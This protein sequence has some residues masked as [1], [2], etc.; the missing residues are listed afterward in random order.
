MVRSEIGGQKAKSQIQIYFR[1][2]NFLTY[3]ILKSLKFWWIWKKSF[4]LFGEPRNQQKRFGQPGSTVNNSIKMV[5]FLSI[6]VNNV[7]YHVHFNANNVT[8]Q[9]NVNNVA[10]IAFMDCIWPL[11]AHFNPQCYGEGV[12]A[13]NLRFVLQGSY[14]VARWFYLHTRNVHHC[15]C[16]VRVY[17]HAFTMISSF[18]EINSTHVSLET[19][20]LRAYCTC[21][22]TTTRKVGIFGHLRPTRARLDSVINAGILK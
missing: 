14:V 22:C 21:S 15:D 20:Y 17:M 5:P 7:V 6:D 10:I 3:S 12:R 16:E 1:I 13:C 4:Y 2:W 18:V 19:I 8:F 9:N 11:R